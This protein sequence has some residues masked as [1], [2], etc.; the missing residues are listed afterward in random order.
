MIKRNTDG[1]YTV[2]GMVTCLSEQAALALLEDTGVHAL[3]DPLTM[4][5]NQPA[6]YQHVVHFVTDTTY[7]AVLRAEVRLV[8]T[9]AA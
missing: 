7:G 8:D 6:R 3:V 1:T 4:Q 2:A 9:Q 5:A